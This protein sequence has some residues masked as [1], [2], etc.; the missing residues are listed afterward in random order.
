MMV[1]IIMIALAFGAFTLIVWLLK[2]KLIIQYI[3]NPPGIDCSAI[4]KKENL[5]DLQ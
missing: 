1:S 2:R 4:A 3:K 5:V